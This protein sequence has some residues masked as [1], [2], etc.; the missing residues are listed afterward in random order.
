MANIFLH[1]F[2]IAKY[3]NNNHVLN[4]TLCYSFYLSHPN[5]S[6]IFASLLQI[7]LGQFDFSFIAV[8]RYALHFTSFFSAPDIPSIREE[9]GSVSSLSSR[10]EIYSAASK[11]DIE[12]DAEVR[13][14]NKRER[15]K[16]NSVVHQF[17]RTY[18][19]VTTKFRKTVFPEA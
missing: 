8:F 13:E 14:I 12:S 15:Q 9:K 17:P 1:T 19:D 18:H 7:P 4:F 5:E 16:K 2:G 10:D 3:I 6:L 11:E